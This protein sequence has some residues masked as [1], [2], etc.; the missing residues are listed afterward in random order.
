MNVDMKS[1]ALPAQP[2]PFTPVLIAA[3][4]WFFIM[5][6]VGR[7]ELLNGAPPQ[8]PGLMV[9]SLVTLQIAAFRK[10][11]T[12]REWA[13]SVDLRLP[14]L[15]HLVR[16]V[17]VCFLFLHAQE[18]LPG[19]FALPAGWGDIAIAALAPAAAM[20]ASAPG[21][22]SRWGAGIWNVLGLAD[23]LMAV[24]MGMNAGMH[25]PRIGEMMTTVPFSLLPTFIV[26]LAIGSHLLIAVR[27]YRKRG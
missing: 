2:S 3:A 13:L 10:W 26:P 16:F 24:A 8:A 22:S 19:E 21:R 4:A 9:L 20:M 18:R 6:A 1:T 5:L 23:I 11:D 27:L 14:V 7:L 15:F 12:F 25:D 17:G